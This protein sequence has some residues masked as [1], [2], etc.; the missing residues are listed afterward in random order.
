[1]GNLLMILGT[2]AMAGGAWLLW[3][4]RLAAEQERGTLLELCRLLGD[5]IDTLEHP[6]AAPPVREA[7]ATAVAAVPPPPVN[8]LAARV[9]Q[10]ADEGK[11]ATEITRIVGKE[12]GVVDLILRLR[13]YR[14]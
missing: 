13:S 3:Q 9:Y 10:L 4:S 5:L 2:L 6:K 14:S 12:R 1:M 11:D 8:A 7:P